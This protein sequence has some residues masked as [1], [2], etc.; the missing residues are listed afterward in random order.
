[1]FSLCTG[2]AT[3]HFCIDFCQVNK[4]TMFPI[5]RVDDCVDKVGNTKYV[6][7]KFKDLLKGYWQVP[8]T[9]RAKEISAFAISDGLSPYK[10]MPF[11]MKNVPATFQHL[12]NGVISGLEGCNAYIDD[13][14][15]YSK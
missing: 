11:G 12:I 13:M 10:V 6:M 15:V 4:A 1:M 5:P 9:S 2:G 3:Y 14:V 7:M 8:L